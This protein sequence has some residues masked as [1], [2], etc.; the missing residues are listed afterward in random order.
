MKNKAIRKFV[1]FAFLVVIVLI[2]AI[3]LLFN[4]LFFNPYANPEA[5]SASFS[6]ITQLISP[7]VTQSFLTPKEPIH[8]LSFGTCSQE[9][10]IRKDSQLHNTWDFDS[11]GIFRYRFGKITISDEQDQLHV[12]D[13]TVRQAVFS[14]AH[15][16]ADFGTVD[17]EKYYDIWIRF[18]EPQPVQ[19]IYDAYPNLIDNTLSRPDKGGVIWIPIQ[20]SEDPNTVCIGMAGNYSWHDVDYTYAL[21]INHYTMTSY[22]R[23]YEFKW[24]LNYLIQNPSEATV[25]LQSGLFGEDL[26]IDFQERLHYVTDHGIYCLGIVAYTDGKTVEALSSDPRNEVVKIAEA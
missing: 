25:L 22:D 12:R 23:E 16:N 2:L 10:I 17:P 11:R 21:G 7:S 6:T 8:L 26:A 5:M 13:S 3:S 15:D 9:F 20:T 18:D 1:F 19:Y 4:H 14:D 24:V